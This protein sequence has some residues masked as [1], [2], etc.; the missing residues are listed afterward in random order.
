MGSAR[1]SRPSRAGQQRSATVNRPPKSDAWNNLGEML[2][3]VGHALN[4]EAAISARDAGRKTDI[5]YQMPGIEYHSREEAFAGEVVA[6]LSQRLSEIIGAPR[7]WKKSRHVPDWNSADDLWTRALESARF[8]STVFSYRDA[9]AG[10]WRPVAGRGID[11]APDTSREH[12]CAHA[13]YCVIYDRVQE[14]YTDGRY[15]F[16]GS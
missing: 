14:L 8:V 2:Y 10:E 11:G 9:A 6:A 13:L 16:A 1:I 12:A 15:A 5:R 4:V 7:Y 3:A